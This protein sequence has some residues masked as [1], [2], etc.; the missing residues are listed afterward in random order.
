MSIYETAGTFLAGMV[1]HKE[2]NLRESIN[3]IKSLMPVVQSYRGMTKEDKAI[4]QNNINVILNQQLLN[5]HEIEKNRISQAEKGP[6]FLASF[7]LIAFII[8]G[9][10]TLIA[11]GW[12]IIVSIIFLSLAGFCGLG[13]VSLLTSNRS[14]RRYHS[15]T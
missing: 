4:H 2:R 10:I 9:L 6:V 13:I 8:F 3:T 11:G 1:G 5:L 14:S 7:F 15:V 12:L